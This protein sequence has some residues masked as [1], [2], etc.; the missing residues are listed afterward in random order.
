MNGAY[1]RKWEL[2]RFTWEGTTV[3]EEKTRGVGWG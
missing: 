2:S 1:I 3:L